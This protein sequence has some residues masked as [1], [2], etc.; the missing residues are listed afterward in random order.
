MGKKLRP[1]GLSKIRNRKVSQSMEKNMTNAEQIAGIKDAIRAQKFVVNAAQIDFSDLRH[2]DNATRASVTK[3]HDAHFSF[4]ENTSA[5]VA[6][7]EWVANFRE[8]LF[9]VWESASAAHGHIHALKSTAESALN[10]AKNY[11]KIL[12][13]SLVLAEA[14]D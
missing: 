14:T 7:E 1:G 10:T 6:N 12:D 9:N 5:N 8:T 11:L 2:A 4:I 13:D 3:S